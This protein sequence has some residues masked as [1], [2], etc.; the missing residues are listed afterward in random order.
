MEIKYFVYSEGFKDGP[1]D[2]A[3]AVEFLYS[4][5]GSLWAPP[6]RLENTIVYSKTRIYKNVVRYR[7]AVLD[8]KYS[9]THPKQEILSDLMGVV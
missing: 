8:G 2:K 7:G 3:E 1:F 6:E 5:C 4:L 9:A